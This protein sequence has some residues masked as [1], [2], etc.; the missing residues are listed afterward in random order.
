MT[1]SIILNFLILGIAAM[2]LRLAIRY[3]ELDRKLDVIIGM[4]ENHEIPQHS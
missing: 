2:L 1:D 4:L 3:K